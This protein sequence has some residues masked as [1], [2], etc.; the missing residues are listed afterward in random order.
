[1]AGDHGNNW[2]AGY[3]GDD[4]VSGG[5]G[6]DWLLGG[7]GNDTVDGG[8][9]RMLAAEGN[10]EAIRQHCLSDVQLTYSVAERLGLL[11]S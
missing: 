9:V 6:D 8:D 3:A 11:R 2:M 4:S 10:W 7:A 5:T 1:M